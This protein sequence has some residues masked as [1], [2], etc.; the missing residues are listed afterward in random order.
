MKKPEVKSI[1]SLMKYLRDN[2]HIDISGSSQKRKL[3][4]MGYYHGFKGYRYI[5]SPTNRIP[6]NDFNQIVAVNDFDMKL[7]AL[8]YP[9]IMFIETTIKNYVLEVV[10]QEGKSQNFNQIYNNLL[11]DYKKYPIG[12]EDYKKAIKKRLE[13]RDTIYRALTQNY[14][15]H[16]RVVQH[17][18]HKDLSVPVWGIFELLTLGEFGF[19]VSCLEFKCRQKISNDIGL[20][21]S[22]DSNAR[23]TQTTIYTIREL[24]NAV[25]HNEVVFDARFRTSTIGN[26]LIRCLEFDTKVNHINFI[27]IVDYLILV[28]YL[29]KNFLVA[30][31]ELKKIISDF[32]NT[33]ESLRRQIPIN[34]YSQIIPTDTRN[35]LAALRK[36]IRS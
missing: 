2:H 23:L 31:T 5:N 22:C 25:A 14:K 12:N 16:R 20:N 18:Y 29:L 34:I 26:P 21:Q 24:R 30:R 17:F 11:T 1:D 35:K 36:F 7:K 3:R 28:V 15:N 8:L 6:Y 13:L 10:I 33:S 9:H 27:T 19:F 32:Q 4:N